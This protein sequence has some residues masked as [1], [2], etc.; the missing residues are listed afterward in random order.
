[1]TQFLKISFKTG[2]IVINTVLYLSVV[3]N[4]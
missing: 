1:V 3:K 4:K 2:V